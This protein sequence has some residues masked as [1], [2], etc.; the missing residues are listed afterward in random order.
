[1]ARRVVRTPLMLL[2]RNAHT[3]PAAML[4]DVLLRHRNVDPRAVDNR[5]WTALHYATGDLAD[6]FHPEPCLRLQVLLRSRGH[7]GGG[8]GAAPFDVDDVNAYGESGRTPLHLL[9]EARDRGPSPAHRDDQDYDTQHRLMTKTRALARLVRAGADVRARTG[10]RSSSETTITTTW[11]EVLARGGAGDTP[12]HLALLQPQELDVLLTTRFLLRHGAGPDVNYV[13]PSLGL[14]P[15][16]IIAAAAGRGELSRNA[17]EEVFQLLLAAG[18]DARLRDPLG[19]RTAWDIFMGLKGSLPAVSP[20][21]LCLEGVAP[22]DGELGTN[23]NSPGP[24]M[25]L[26]L[27]KEA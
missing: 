15:L 3:V 2:C 18:A 5:G 21:R 4:I 27:M 12:L 20:W 26:A 13:S 8:E 14:T 9:L 7:E 16:M 1:M 23:S 17:T 6:P 19:G 11:P 25:R 10:K 22:D 24:K